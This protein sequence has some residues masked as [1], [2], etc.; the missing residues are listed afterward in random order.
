VIVSD[1]I[2]LLFTYLIALV[3]IVGGG[4]AVYASRLDP[5]DSNAQNVAL[6]FA[7]FIGAAISFVFGR[8]TATQ[9]TRASQSSNAAGVASQNGDRGED[10]DHAAR[11]HGV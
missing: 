8:E 3:V 9:A 5:A 6:M 11:K 7:G 10:V 4:A 1:N 2:K